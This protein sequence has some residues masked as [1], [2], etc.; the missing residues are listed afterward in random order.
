VTIAEGPFAGGTTQAV[1]Y[2]R[3]ALDSWYR[4]L[5]ERDRVARMYAPQ[6][7]PAQAAAFT[8][9]AASDPAGYA[10]AVSKYGVVGHAQT[11]ARAR[12][13]GRPIILRRDFNTT[14]GA[15]AGL[16][17]VS[18]QRSIED[19]VTVR[20]AMNASAAQLANPSITST[21]NNGI[22]EFIFVVR[23]ANYLLPPRRLRAFPLVPGREE[24]LRA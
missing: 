7:T 9:D 22:N 4:G 20:T 12:R 19:F 2:M 11:S 6:V 8:T 5:S 21:V 17:F 15:Q 24:A 3:L 14:D 13:G 16:H 1:S 23:R 18:L 10:E